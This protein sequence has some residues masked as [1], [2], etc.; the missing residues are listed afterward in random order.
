MAFKVKLKI[1][2]EVQT[3][4]KSPVN[5]EFTLCGDQ[6][7]ED[8]SVCGTQVIGDIHGDDPVTCV[9]CLEVIAFCKNLKG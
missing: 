5:P 2:G 1:N 9:P 8:D 6:W 3:H 7:V 4:C